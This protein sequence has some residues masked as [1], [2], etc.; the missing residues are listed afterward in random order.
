MTESPVEKP[1]RVFLS[2]LLNV[3][4]FAFMNLF[5]KLASE[6]H[7]IAQIMFFRSVI[8]LIPVCLMILAKRDISL[9]STKRMGGHF[10]RSSI[11]TI[12]MAF[13]FTSFAMLPMADATAIQFASPLILTALSV[14][15]LKEIVGPHRWAAVTIGL[16][17]VLFMLQ[18]TG[19]THMAGNMVA[20]GAAF[21]GA[22]AMI[23]V[24]R[25]GTTE[26]SLTIV[27]YFSLFS[28]I[29]SFIA[30]LFAWTP[31][32]ATSLTYLLAA[33]ILGGFGQVFLTYCYA[34]APAA[35][36]S[37][38]SYLAILFSALFDVIIWH[39]ATDWRIALGSC[40]VMSSGLYIV[41]REAKKHYR[42]ITNPNLYNL[43]PAM[44]TPRDEEKI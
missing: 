30:M 43:Q 26:H 15:L 8:A 40:I 22:L 10:A 37:P 11:G 3:A 14:P 1:F 23:A 25:L 18:P 13:F 31:P 2:A 4:F 44:P 32:T 5:V 7:S 38:F 17:A 34:R 35:Y 41:F 24:R 39:H 42:N 6:T 29:F 19:H 33:G 36:V 28:A 9:F 12:S 21:L 27:F 20:L 16:G